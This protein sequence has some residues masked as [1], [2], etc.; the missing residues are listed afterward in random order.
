MAEVSLLLHSLPFKHVEVRRG[1]LVAKLGNGD[2]V[3]I[4][5][6][7]EDCEIERLFINGIEV[8]LVRP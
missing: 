1:K 6:I 8:K 5:A 7:A 2:E 3:E 4:G